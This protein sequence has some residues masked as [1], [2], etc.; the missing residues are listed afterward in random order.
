MQTYWQNQHF[1]ASG[2]ALVSTTNKFSFQIYVK[3]EKIN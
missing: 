3:K 1:F 2:G